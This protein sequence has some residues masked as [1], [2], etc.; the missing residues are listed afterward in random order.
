M[1]LFLR[2]TALSLFLSLSGFS[3]WAQA[4]QHDPTF[5]PLQVKRSNAEVSAIIV[6]PDGKILINGTYH[7]LNNAPVR[8]LTRLHPDGSLDPTF[9]EPKEA[10]DVRFVARRADGKIVAASFT[11]NWPREPKMT[12]H[13]L[14]PNGNGE[15]SF[16]TTLSGFTNPANIFAVLPDNKILVGLGSY[17]AG[18]YATRIHRLNPD[19]TIDPGF[20]T[21]NQKMGYITDMVVQPD[22]K[23]LL[24]GEFQ[25]PDV[26]LSLQMIRLNADGSFDHSFPWITGDQLFA[27]AL[28]PN[29]KILVGRN[30]YG[31]GTGIFRLN[32]DGT[33]D[34][35][36]KAAPLPHGFYYSVYSFVV[37]PDGKIVAG[38]HWSDPAENDPFG[39]GQVIRL[40]ADGSYD[41]G[42]DSG[43][44]AEYSIPLLSLQP[45]GNVLAG[46]NFAT[47]S[48]QA[49]AGV[50]CLNGT[51]G[52]LNNSFKAKLET[53]GFITDL[54]RQGD[55]KLLVSGGFHV[56][57]GQQYAG[58]TRLNADGTVDLGFQAVSAPGA[59]H[60]LNADPV[61]A[62]A[63]QSDYKI[64][65][66]GRFSSPDSY[67]TQMLK[68]LNSDGSPDASF[69]PQTPQGEFL[70][71]VAV[72]ADDKIVVGLSGSPFNVPRL[73]R[74][75][76][77]G[78]T[79]NSF[80]I[81]PG[82][83]SHV[84]QVLVQADGKV[85]ANGTFTVNNSSQKL[86]RFNP[87]GT[88][89][90]TFQPVT[91]NHLINQV[92]L[93]PDGRILIAGGF[94]G[95]GATPV[96][97]LA[98]LQADG[99]LDDS[100]HSPLLANDFIRN[101]HV[102]ADGKVL[103]TGSFPSVNR[104]VLRL[105]ADGTLDNSF[106]TPEFASYPYFDAVLGQG[107]KVVLASQGKLFRITAPLEQ[108]ITFGP[109]PGKITTDAGFFL[110][111]S[112]SS[113]LPVTFVV[114]SGPATV[115][116]NTVTLTGE[117]GTVTIRAIQAGDG[118]Y[119]PAP[120]VEQ[121]FAVQSAPEPGPDSM[122]VRTFP[123]P[124]PGQFMVKLAGDLLVSSIGLF[125][126]MGKPVA[127]TFVRMPFGYKVQAPGAQP[128]LYV[129][130]LQT[131]KGRIS[132]R[133]AFR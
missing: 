41:A 24:V 102:Q 107:D 75:N 48:G 79:D 110:S 119:K 121:S 104:K 73:F 22:G 97:R 40:N 96:L 37:Q 70:N 72:Q 44:G 17:A 52:S 122:E 123:N 109:L 71:A 49:K 11:N 68:R 43:T 8:G 113:G 82:L 19:G 126:A 57:G 101:L 53:E 7:F 117:P 32:S 34:N 80:Q 112:A 46:G 56:A 93:Q 81:T 77:D 1:N 118:V 108:T 105:N 45:N 18:A 92:K 130:E 64:V 15:A 5:S 31:T 78:T 61:R 111:A 33:V 6:Q 21:V 115:A 66:G 58:L 38:S 51:N 9:Q 26:Q 67:E 129:L 87:N 94:S 29:G 89:D 76:A 54:I 99:S 116:G 4:Y 90:E 25:H 39:H 62:L 16:P 3:A 42:F 85:L 86:L 27:L 127:A 14:G 124:A 65:V 133:I 74:L 91:A 103:L 30:G 28:Q 95:I 83:A 35:S 69:L 12:L 84:S 132:K 88:L 59:V 131:D 23:T 114:L 2:A 120:A 106:A 63:V 13:L 50:F 98:R 60:V 20:S 47:Y 128:G 55:G 125:D 100:F 10:E 36:F